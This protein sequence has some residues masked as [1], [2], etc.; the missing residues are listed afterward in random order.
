MIPLSVT[1]SPAVRMG[2]RSA[3]V[4]DVVPVGTGARV[5]GAIATEL[6][7]WS[8]VGSS[9]GIFVL[10]ES[11]GG[12]VGLRVGFLAFLAFFAVHNVF[13]FFLFPL[14]RLLTVLTSSSVNL[15]D[16]LSLG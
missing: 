2:P 12:S 7:D 6:C 11:K 10:D 5:S 16:E 3:A 14:L 13:V 15:L 8:W 1:A 9:V 4:G